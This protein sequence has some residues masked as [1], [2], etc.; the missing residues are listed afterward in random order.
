MKLLR[1]L[2]FGISVATLNKCLI[3]TGK[4]DTVQYELAL[5]LSFLSFSRLP[6]LL[7]TVLRK[8]FF[9]IGQSLTSLRRH[10]P[11][12]RRRVVAT[13]AVAVA[14][15]VAALPPQAVPSPPSRSLLLSP[16]QPSLLT[17]TARAAAAAAKAASPCTGGRAGPAP[18]LRVPSHGGV[19][20]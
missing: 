7:L 9:Q 2:N 8:M 19:E 6:L 3:R 4:N 15:A 11:G 18:G 20:N 17:A 10:C 14:V 13:V 5:H 12:R 1:P 16:P